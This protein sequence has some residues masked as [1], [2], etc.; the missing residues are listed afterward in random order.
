MSARLAGASVGPVTPGP[1]TLSVMAI[2]QPGRLP[3][4]SQ[5]VFGGARLPVPGREALDG[6]QHSQAVIFPLREELRTLRGELRPPELHLFLAR[7]CALVLGN[8]WDYM[9]DTGAAGRLKAVGFTQ[10]LH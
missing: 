6:P 10:F 7:A 9:N 4:S 5:Y 2:T 8:A 3:F 1:P